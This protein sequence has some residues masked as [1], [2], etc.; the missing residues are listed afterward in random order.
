MWP[1]EGY[2]TKNLD[3]AAA[4]REFH[5]VLRFVAVALRDEGW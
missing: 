1:E 2:L 4:P 5:S 3:Y